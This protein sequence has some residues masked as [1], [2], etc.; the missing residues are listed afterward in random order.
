MENQTHH[1]INRLSNRQYHQNI[2]IHNIL[3]HQQLLNT[4]IKQS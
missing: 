2:Q 4:H 1:L 3:T